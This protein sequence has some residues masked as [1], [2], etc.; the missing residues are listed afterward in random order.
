[1]IKT[2]QQREAERLA[3]AQAVREANTARIAPYKWTKENPPRPVSARNRLQGSFLHALAD[4]FDK[5][6]KMAIDYARRN[7]PMGYIKCIAS[8]MPKQLEQTT[9][10]EDLNDAELV[11][12]IALLKSRLSVEAGKGTSLPAIT[13]TIDHVSTVSKT[14]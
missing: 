1:M 8:L 14:T 12:G 2:V 13:E 6:G 7:D 9:P 5:H 11:A 10:M 3:K 4:D